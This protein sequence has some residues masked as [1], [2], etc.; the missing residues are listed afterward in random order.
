MT[1]GIWGCILFESKE[2]TPRPPK[3][4]CQG[5][6]RRHKLHIPRRCPSG[7]GSLIP[8]LLLF[9]PQTLRLLCGGSPIFPPQTPLK[10]PKEGPAGPSFGNHPRGGETGVWF[11]E[12]FRQDGRGRALSRPGAGAFAR[13]GLPCGRFAAHGA[14]KWNPI[15][16]RAEICYTPCSSFRA[17]RFAGTGGGGAGDGASTRLFPV[18]ARSGA[19]WQSVSFV[20]GLVAAACS[21]G[22]VGPPLRG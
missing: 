8:L 19:T 16:Q 4:D 21:G 11:L 9:P 1:C 15:N 3:K 20:G 5:G 7:T 13:D 18:I 10:R 12:Y 2:Y 6:C 22:H 14:L 17:A